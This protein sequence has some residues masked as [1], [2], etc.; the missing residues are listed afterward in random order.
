MLI[1]LNPEIS[2]EQYIFEGRELFVRI[3]GQ[4]DTKKLKWIKGGQLDDALKNVEKYL[5]KKEQPIWL[6]VCLG[7]GFLIK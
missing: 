6:H 1:K 4:L 3:Q 2:K 5:R 7:Q